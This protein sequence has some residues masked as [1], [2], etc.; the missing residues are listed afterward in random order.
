MF[1]LRNQSSYI[2][3]GKRTTHAW[4]L[5]PLCICFEVLTEVK[6]VVCNFLSHHALWEKNNNIL[7]K[8]PAAIFP[9][10]Y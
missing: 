5:C 9:H 8:P 3:D 2:Y 4:K 10:K 7:E 6:F 1:H